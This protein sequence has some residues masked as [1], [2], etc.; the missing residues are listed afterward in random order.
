MPFF[1][2]NIYSIVNGKHVFTGKPNM[3]RVMEVSEERAQQVFRR[4]D[5][6]I[7]VSIEKP[8]EK[9]VEEVIPEPVKKKPG[10]PRKEA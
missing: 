9:V 7:E 2:P 4:Q 8:K 6:W 5:Q 3:D 1:A 10:R